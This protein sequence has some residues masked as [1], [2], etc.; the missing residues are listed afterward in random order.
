MIRGHA[1][2]P[3]RRLSPSHAGNSQVR[4]LNSPNSR[5]LAYITYGLTSF[6]VSACTRLPIEQLMTKHQSS[7]P[8]ETTIRLYALYGYLCFSFKPLSHAYVRICVGE[9]LR[10]PTNPRIFILVFFNYGVVEAWNRIL[11][12]RMLSFPV[13]RSDQRCPHYFTCHVI[14]R[15]FSLSLT[16]LENKAQPVKCSVTQSVCRY[17]HRFSSG[18]DMWWGCTEWGHVIQTNRLD[19]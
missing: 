15:S 8:N 1:T 3:V 10:K 17:P 16:A 11:S 7:Y 19:Y 5:V 14:S 2:T 18:Y 9:K 6:R 13:S 12:P 4:P